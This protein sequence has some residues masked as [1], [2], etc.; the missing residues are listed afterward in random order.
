MPARGQHDTDRGEHRGPDQSQIGA[1]ARDGERHDRAIIPPPIRRPYG[2][3][4]GSSSPPRP[5]T[6]ARPYTPPP[7]WRVGRMSGLTQPTG[8]CGAPRGYRYRYV[9][10]QP[11]G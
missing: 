6:T 4:S 1:G 11:G 2:R 8:L 3:V 5:V 10:P 9:E 7:A